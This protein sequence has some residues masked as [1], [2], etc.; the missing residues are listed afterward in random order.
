MTKFGTNASGAIWWPNL[1]VMQPI[2]VPLKSILKHLTWIFLATEFANFVASWKN[3]SNYRS[4]AWVRCASGNVLTNILSSRN[5]CFIIYYGMWDES[6]LSWM[7]CN[8]LELWNLKVKF[9]WNWWERGVGCIWDEYVSRVRLQQMCIR[10]CLAANFIL[11]LF[12]SFLFS[13]ELRM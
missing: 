11:K 1:E 9:K 8:F 4:N 2:Q 3:N 13:V 12:N 7:K 6:L 5:E 10:T